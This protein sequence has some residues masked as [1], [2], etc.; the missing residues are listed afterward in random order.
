MVPSSGMPAPPSR[1]GKRFDTSPPEHYV[2]LEH[3]RTNRSVGMRTYYDIDL[4]GRS[5]TR[6]ELHGE[7]IAGAGA[8]LVAKALLELGPAPV[9]PLSPAI[10]LIFSAGPFAGTSFSNANRTS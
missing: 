7:D 8:Y 9:H 4:T 3:T 1:L 2:A 6:R 10:P 5:I